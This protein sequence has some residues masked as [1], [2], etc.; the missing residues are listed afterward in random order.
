MKSFEG[1]FVVAV[2]PFNKSGSLDTEALRENI[3]FYIKN[4]V[5][6][7]V[8]TGSTGE[9]AA[10]SDE[11]I[12]KIHETAVEHVNGRVPLIA[13]TAACSTKKVIEITSY[14]KNIGV[15]GALIVPPFY[16]K[17]DDE[18]I[19]KHYEN[20]GTSVELPIM[21][22]NNPFTSKID[23][24]P[25]LISKISE[26]DN[27]KYVKESSGDITRIWKILELTRGK[28]TVFCGADNLALESFVMGAKGWICVAANIFPRETSR[29]Y[30]IANFE[31]DYRRAL[32]H[33]QALL[34]LYNFLEDTGKFTH[35]AK[36]GLELRG[37]KAGSPR[38]PFLPLSEHHRRKVKE[39]I[40]NIQKINLK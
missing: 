30:E 20:I 4:E 22:Y 37:M 38:E 13:G 19:F 1:T 26:I 23:I 10:L 5:H 3:D 18:E 7:I 28:I 32:E 12:K 36:Y 33:Y 6:G 15:D 14:A 2:T 8:V 25:E 17:I 9:F 16:S 39:I 35:T 11:E 34:P 29:L 27:I 24:K 21:L 40:K 31:K